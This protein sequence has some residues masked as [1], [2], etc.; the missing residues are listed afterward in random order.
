MPSLVFR[1]S[2]T[3]DIR[4]LFIDGQLDFAE[5]NLAYKPAGSA[6][7]YLAQVDSIYYDHHQYLHADIQFPAIGLRVRIMIFD[8]RTIKIDDQMIQGQS[9]D[10]DLPLIPPS[11]SHNP[12]GIFRGPDNRIIYISSICGDVDPN[13]F[14][15]FLGTGTQ[16]Q[17]AVL[18]RAFV[19]RPTS[20][21]TRASGQPAILAITNAGRF[22]ITEP[23]WRSDGTSYYD[24]EEGAMRTMIA[25]R[26]G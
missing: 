6:I 17:Q 25:P 11:A 14:R 13:N 23:D 8:T 22:N 5:D 12:Y 9:E 7:A 20:T 4:L 19:I 24:I 10:T 15:F 16:D 26:V 1:L 21:R 2:D 18:R 3:N